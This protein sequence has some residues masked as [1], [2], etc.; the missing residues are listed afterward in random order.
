MTK[1]DIDLFI[2]REA[3]RKFDVNGFKDI[4]DKPKYIE[5]ANLLAPFLLEAMV[6]LNEMKYQAMRQ[7]GTEGEMRD[8]EPY[9]WGLVL[10]ALVKIKEAI[11]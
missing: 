2:E 3:A 9:P 4:Y 8:S 10:D 1:Q 6:A 7:Y 11:K 5:G